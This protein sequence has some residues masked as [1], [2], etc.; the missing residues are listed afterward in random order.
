MV[1][2][3]VQNPKVSVTKETKEILD[4]FKPSARA[5]YEDT[6][7]CLIKFIPKKVKEEIQK[8]KLKSTSEVYYIPEL[9]LE[10]FS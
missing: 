6:I 1:E 5:T 7:K 8:M 2:K 4:E 3:R 9:V 10:K